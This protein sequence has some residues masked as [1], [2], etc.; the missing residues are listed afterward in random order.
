MDRKIIPQQVYM[1]LTTAAIITLLL[2]FI[3]DGVY[4]FKWMSNLGN[5]IAFGIYYLLLF[6]GQFVIYLIIVKIL[7][8]Q[9]RMFLS[10]TLGSILGLVIAIGY[11]FG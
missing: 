10:I 1:L 9:K 6:L 8:W 7:G 4:N 5:W 3:N 11:V 2:F